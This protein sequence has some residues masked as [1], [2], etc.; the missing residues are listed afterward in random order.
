M[1]QFEID[2]KKPMQGVQSKGIYNLLVT[3]RDIN[4]YCLGIIP[5]RH[6]KINDIKK[7]FGLNGNKVTIK[8]KIN[9][10]FDRALLGEFN[11]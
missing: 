3:K 11:N 5:N 1:T 6:F 8:T 10:L 7:Y 4:L 9:Q 2:L